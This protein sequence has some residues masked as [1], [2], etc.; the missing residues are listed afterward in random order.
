MNR[1]QRREAKRKGILQDPDETEGMTLAEW[2]S[3]P[4]QIARRGEVW[5]AIGT[6]I[7]LHE[8]QK[9]RNRWYNRAIYA[10]RRFFH[11]HLP[12]LSGPVPE[13]PAP[14][15]GMDPN[16]PEEDDQDGE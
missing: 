11:R 4:D 5:E 7:T 13:P 1:Q 8:R 6:A 14:E 2:L 15:P 3:E 12:A 16:P 10:V 9:V